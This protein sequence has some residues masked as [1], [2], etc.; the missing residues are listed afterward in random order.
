MSY[1]C[2]WILSSFGSGFEIERYRIGYTAV[3][4]KRQKFFAIQ[5]VLYNINNPFRIWNRTIR[6]EFSY[7]SVKFQFILWKHD[8][9]LK[10]TRNGKFKRVNCASFFPPRGPPHRFSVMAAVAVSGSSAAPLRDF[11]NAKMPQKILFW[12]FLPLCRDFFFHVVFRRKIIAVGCANFLKS[13]FQVTLAIFG[14]RTTPR[15]FF[16]FW[17]KHVVSGN[18]DNWRD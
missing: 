10:I 1:K 14:N 17:I 5:K 8:E 6:F 9:T 11:A 7:I 12:S 3:T 16:D 4:I 13:R 15:D 18:R 2:I